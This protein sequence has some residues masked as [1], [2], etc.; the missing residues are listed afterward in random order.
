MTKQGFYCEVSGKLAEILID[1][2]RVPIVEDEAEVE[3]V[4]AKPIKWIGKLEGKPGNGWYE[5]PIGGYKH[6]KIL[7]GRPKV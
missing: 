7:V 1:K 5:R 4:L 6:N 3:K 2:Y